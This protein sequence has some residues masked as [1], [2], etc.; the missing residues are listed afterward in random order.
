M[1]PDLRNIVIGYIDNYRFQ[2]DYC[3]WEMNI[4]FRE[5]YLRE[6]WDAWGRVFLADFYRRDVFVPIWTNPPHDNLMYDI[7]HF[8]FR[9]S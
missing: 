8:S 6:T 3:V 4:R 5:M 9:K 7:Q 1:I 2:Y